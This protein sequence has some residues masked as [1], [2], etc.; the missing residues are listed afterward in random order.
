MPQLSRRNLITGAGVVAAGAVAASAL[1]LSGCGDDDTTEQDV[2]L[3]VASA[4]QAALP[5]GEAL[6]TPSGGD[7]GL[8]STGI[9]DLKKAPDGKGFRYDLDGWNFLH[10]EGAPKARGYQHGYLLAS[11]ID[12]AIRNMQGVAVVDYGLPW[13]Y[14]KDYVSKQWLSKIEAEYRQELEGIVSGLKAQKKAYDLADLVLYNGFGEVYDYWW[15]TVQDDYYKN[16]DTKAADQ[17]VVAEPKQGAD[18]HCSAFIATGS[19]TKDGHIVGAHN[20]FTP[21]EVGNYL[22]VCIDVQ[23]DQGQHFIM[24]AQPGFIHS[25]SDFYESASLIVTET[26]IGGF[27]RYDASGTPEFLRIRKAVQYAKD[28]DKFTAIMLDG[29][30]GG[31]AN[32]WLIGELASDQIA[33]LE[34]GLKFHK[35]DRLKDGYFVGFNAPEDPYVRNLECKDSGYADIRRHQGARQVRLPQLMEQNKGKIDTEVA[36]TILADHFDVYLNK[37]NPSSRTV[38]GHYE[39]DAREYMSMAGRPY[40]FQPRGAVDGVCGSTTTAKDFTMLGRFGS[41]CGAAFVAADFFS[42]HP[43]FNYLASY[44]KDRPSRPW[45]ELKAQTTPA[46]SAATS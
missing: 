4:V 7:A 5:K 3:A 42:A 43:Q 35:L 33:R 38:C 27:Y 46:L 32:T 17:L 9:Q 29:N 34:L 1:S 45:A 14:A 10:I 41:S 37:Q 13:C 12:A 28:I 36:K 39:V 26:T 30:T 8:K 31:Y 21:F 6:K 18:D 25:Y 15:P 44:I 16:M 20:S 23:P 22:N 24:Q 11:E 2:D 40:P 19:Y